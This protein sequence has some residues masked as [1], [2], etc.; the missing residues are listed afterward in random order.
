MLFLVLSGRDGLKI[1]SSKDV[2]SLRGGERTRQ[3]V[4]CTQFTMCEL[5]NQVIEIF[6]PKLA[7]I[8]W[9]LTQSKISF[10]KCS[11]FD[12]LEVSYIRLVPLIKIREKEKAH[13][14]S[15]D[16]FWVREYGILE[17]QNPAFARNIL[18][19]MRKK[20]SLLHSI[21]FFDVPLQF[22]KHSQKP[23]NVFIL[24][25]IHMTKMSPKCGICPPSTNRWKI[26]KLKFLW[27]EN[28]PLIMLYLPVCRMVGCTAQILQKVQTLVKTDSIL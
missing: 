7:F 9:R 5:W 17:V 1:P 8:L 15:K 28:L 22:H 14:P 19:C 11:R 10:P 23:K 6:Q 24:K 18:C 4:C 3:Q 20:I 25:H 26:M 12:C 21:S 13:I 16:V 27:A 2:R